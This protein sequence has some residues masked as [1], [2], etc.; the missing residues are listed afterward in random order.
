LDRRHNDQSN[1]RA[2]RSER[3]RRRAT[4]DQNCCWLFLSV[5]NSVQGTNRR[6]CRC[7]CADGHQNHARRRTGVAGSS[8]WLAKPSRVLNNLVSHQDFPVAA[9]LT[10]EFRV[11]RRFETPK[12]ASPLVLHRNRLQSR[13]E[14]WMIAAHDPASSRSSHRS[15]GEDSREK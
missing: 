6:N 11:Q 2:R 12:I 15:A 8:G 1:V 3:T 4:A 14:F 13:A 7:G 9:V 10:G 5:A